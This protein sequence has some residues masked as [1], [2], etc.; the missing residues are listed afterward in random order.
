MSHGLASGHLQWGDK[1]YEFK[2]AP[3]YGEK[4]WGGGFPSKWHWVQCNTFDG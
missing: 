1:R 2:D 4:N 3:S